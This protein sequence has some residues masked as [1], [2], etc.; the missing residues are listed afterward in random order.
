MIHHQADV[1][2]CCPGGQKP[3]CIYYQGLTESSRRGVISGMSSDWTWL[4]VCQEAVQAREENVK[5]CK[6]AYVD[7]EVLVELVS[8]NQLGEALTGQP[9]LQKYCTN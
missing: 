8:E 5:R 4:Q 7:E 9:P 6:L 3:H 1:S 2:A